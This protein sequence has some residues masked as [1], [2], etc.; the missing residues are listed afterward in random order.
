MS[1]NRFFLTTLLLFSSSCGTRHCEEFATSLDEGIFTNLEEEIEG[2]E[3][4]KIEIQDD[5]LW[6]YVEDENGNKWKLSFLI[7]LE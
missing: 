2:F 4:S 5:M 6:L 7:L 3:I 1:I